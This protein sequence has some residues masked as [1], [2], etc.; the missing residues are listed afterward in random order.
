MEKR[1]AE[2]KIFKE[3]QGKLAQR[4]GILKGEGGWNPL[5]NYECACF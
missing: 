2:T 5:M 4:M 3:G 1:G